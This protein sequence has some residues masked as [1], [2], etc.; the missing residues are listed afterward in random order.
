MYLKVQYLEPLLFH[1][2]INDISETAKNAKIRLFAYDTNVFLV[3]DNTNNFKQD[4]QHTLL[5][6]SEW[7]AANKL[8]MINHLPH[9]QN[10]KQY[11]HL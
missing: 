3:S 8:I 4:A 5:E 2:Y 10:Y 9:Q 11:L 7:L 1:I 6:L